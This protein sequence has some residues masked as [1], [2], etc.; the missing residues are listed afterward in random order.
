[1]I[2][3]LDILSNRID[4]FVLTTFMSY[5]V[6]GLDEKLDA[7]RYCED[8]ENENQKNKKKGKMWIS[9]RLSPR[10]I[11]FQIEHNIRF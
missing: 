8:L 7:H 1:M 4:S 9:G 11:S 3:H 6:V 10:G 5:Q 2:N